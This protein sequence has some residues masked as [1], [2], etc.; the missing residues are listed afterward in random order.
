MADSN[1]NAAVSF[2][3]MVASG[4]VQEAYSKFVGEGFRHHNPFFEG[5]AESLQA[6]MQANALQNPDKVMDVK[7]VIAEGELVAVHSHVQQKPGD[8]GA[9]VVHI[10]RFENGHI[11]ELWDLGQPV[12]EESPNQF[13]MF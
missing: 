6:G 9:V 7:R 11:V 10:F 3:K 1:K 8:R 4:K 5:S 12:P 13:G 2:L